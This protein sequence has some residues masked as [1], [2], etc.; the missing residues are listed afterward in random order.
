MFIQL[1]ADRLRRDYANCVDEMAAIFGEVIVEETSKITSVQQE[2]WKPRHAIDL[3]QAGRF[4]SFAR[5]HAPSVDGA[6][7]IE[8]S[9]ATLGSA[10]MSFITLTVILLQ[11][12]EGDVIADYRS[13]NTSTTPV[14]GPIE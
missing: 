12:Q 13:F 9:R 5:A 11:F 6:G 4:R 7:V 1:L 14:A 8:I 2:M 3:E 10:V